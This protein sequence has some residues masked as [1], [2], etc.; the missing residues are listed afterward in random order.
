VAPP[1]LAKRD[2]EIDLNIVD[3]KGEDYKPPPPVLTPFSGAGHSLG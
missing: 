2:E 1:E 3:K